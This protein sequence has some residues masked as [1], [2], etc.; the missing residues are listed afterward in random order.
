MVIMTTGKF[1]SFSNDLEAFVWPAEDQKQQAKRRR[2]LFA[3]SE[4]FIQLGYRKTSIDAI[5]KRAAL[6]KGTI[7]LYYG[8]KA[9]IVLH[10][11]ALEK[12]TH[13]K[14]LVEH[15]RDDLTP[16]DVLRTFI[17]V[18]V[19]MSREMPLTA[20]LLR[21]DQE[22][23]FAMQE[24]AE[25]L[26]VAVGTMRIGAVLELL[27]DATNHELSRTRLKILSHTLVDLLNSVFMSPH[28]LGAE[29]PPI[30]YAQNLADMLIYG[31]VNSNDR[32]SSDALKPLYKKLSK[33][34]P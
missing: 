33:R 5:A 9:E 22:I 7:Y 24:V 13:L 19:V 8:N 29:I 31:L 30:K 18:A 15:I 3:A 4:L 27:D 16:E 6:A 12:L 25:P 34:S 28:T 32:Q 10:A 17:V 14:Q 1:E 20:S 21:G 2:I 23:S 26:K 11:I